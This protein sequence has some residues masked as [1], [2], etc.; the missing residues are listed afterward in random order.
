MLKKLFLFIYVFANVS[1]YLSSQGSMV[2]TKANENNR[3]ISFLDEETTELSNEVSQL[4]L[5]NKIFINKVIGLLNSF[6]ELFEKDSN[7]TLKSYEKDNFKKQINSLR[8]LINEKIK[9]NITEKEH[10]FYRRTIKL[11]DLF[12]ALLKNPDLKNKNTFLDF[13]YRKPANF[14]KRHKIGTAAGLTLAALAGLGLNHL[15]Q[16]SS[17]D[18]KKDLINPIEPIKPNTEL[19]IDKEPV[20]DLVD[21]SEQSDNEDC[22]QFSTTRT[23][24]FKPSNVFKVGGEDQNLDIPENTPNEDDFDNPEPATDREVVRT[25]I[26]FESDELEDS[27]SDSEASSNESSQEGIEIGGG[28][29][30]SDSED[31]G[32][33][34]ED[35]SDIYQTVRDVL[36]EQDDVRITFARERN[37][38]YNF[39]QPKLKPTERF[40]N[41]LRNRRKRKYQSFK[42]LFDMNDEK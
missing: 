2:I 23:K 38:R 9:N 30:A 3:V 37:T 39:R 11:L 35:E 31:A 40:K 16:D 20:Q 28:L 42:Q 14:V 4:V 24:P 18:S 8:F 19:T 41:L 15:K 17:K 26:F 32:D 34:S 22:E 21:P 1:S 13:V 6:S 36:A 7:I 27:S 33:I 5:S 10:D 29:F 25:N 12:E